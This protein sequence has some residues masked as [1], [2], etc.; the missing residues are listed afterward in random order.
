MSHAASNKKFFIP[1]FF[2]TTVYKHICVILHAVIRNCSIPGDVKCR[3]NGSCI[4]SD[5]IC[6]GI[7]DCM[8]GSDEEN[9]SK[10]SYNAKLLN[11]LKW[12]ILNVATYVILPCS[13]SLLGITWLCLWNWL[14]AYLFLWALL[15]RLNIFDLAYTY[16]HGI[17]RRTFLVKFFW[18][19]ICS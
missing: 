14:T 13:H 4:H 10:K 16:I 2:Q 5:R 7:S 8:D 11:L 3:D 9:C 19:Y 12:N 17:Y 18:E 15:K 1:N 6:N